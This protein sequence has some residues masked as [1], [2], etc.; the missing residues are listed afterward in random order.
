MILDKAT[1]KNKR[2]LTKANLMEY[3]AVNDFEVLLTLGAG[4]IDVFVEPIANCLK[5][6][7]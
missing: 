5:N 3:I 6:K 4:D 2:L 7:V 1:A